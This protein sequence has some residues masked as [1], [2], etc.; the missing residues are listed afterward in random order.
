MA[1]R[2]SKVASPEQMLENMKFFCL[3]CDMPLH[4]DFL[5]VHQHDGSETHEIESE[6]FCDA[7]CVGMTLKAVMN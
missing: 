3:N 5:C 6:C 2:R 1:Y 4:V 7:P